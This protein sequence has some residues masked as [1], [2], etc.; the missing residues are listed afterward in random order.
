[1]LY[2]VKQLSQQRIINF[3]SRLNCK[4]DLLLHIYLMQHFSL[5]SHPANIEPF[6]TFLREGK[7][8]FC[9]QKIWKLLQIAFPFCFYCVLKSPIKN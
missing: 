4:R 2:T 6:A 8:E 5:N 3:H 1:M 7:K 9:M